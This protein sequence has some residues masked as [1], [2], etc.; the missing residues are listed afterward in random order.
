M[1]PN[2]PGSSRATPNYGYGVVTLEPKEAPTDPQQIAR[3]V[4]QV[5][6]DPDWKPPLLPVVA[7]QLLEL[8]RSANADFQKV[9]K[10]L[11]QDPALAA[12]LLRRAN[13]AVYGGSVQI[14]SIRDAI[15]RLG[16]NGV[17]SLA[18]EVAMSM[19]VFR[20]PG[21]QNVA[22]VL[23]RHAVATGYLAGIVSRYTPFNGPQA[24]LYGLLAD[25]GLALGLM[26]V[27]ECSKC[28]RGHQRPDISLIWPTLWT[29]HERVS[30]RVSALWKLDADITTVLGCHHSL[31][32]GNVAHPM[33][34]IV[35]VSA[36][37]AG[38]LGAGLSEPLA[39]YGVMV[40]PTPPDIM[41]AARDLLGLNARQLDLARAEGQKLFKDMGGI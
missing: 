3:R 29:I 39:S 38:E 17:C 27:G 2:P 25:V 13:S 32:V 14:L 18:L 7:T 15:A 34:A 11:V 31:R 40:T 30:A 6:D 10:L 35:M 20:V 22:D 41:K 19:R 26:A 9:A 23:R 5:I 37:L 1:P 36:E 33:A 12:Q 28:T 16:L 24:V 8:T 4:V 21:Y